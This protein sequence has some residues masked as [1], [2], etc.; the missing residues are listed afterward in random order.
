MANISDGAIVG[1]AI[2]RVIA[3]YGKDAPK[4]V[5]KFVKEMK[6]AYYVS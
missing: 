3:E 4:Q 5:G 2:V 6:E 1:S